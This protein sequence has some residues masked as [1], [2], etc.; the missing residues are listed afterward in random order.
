[1]PGTEDTAAAIWCKQIQDKRTELHEHLRLNGVDVED[2]WKEVHLGDDYSENKMIL[3]NRQWASKIY[4]ANIA[5]GFSS[6]CV[7]YHI[8]L[9]FN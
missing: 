2:V 1:M 8:L 7:Y 9:T 4:A 5:G 6:C 3:N